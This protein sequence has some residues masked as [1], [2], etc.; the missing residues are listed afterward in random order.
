MILI[1]QSNIFDN[2][3]SNNN[4]LKNIHKILVVITELVKVNFKFIIKR[5]LTFTN[6]FDSTEG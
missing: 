3:L 2:T 5:I 6:L 1:F 4:Q